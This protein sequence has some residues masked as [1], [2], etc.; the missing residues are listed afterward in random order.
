[1]EFMQPSQT[2]YLTFT[3]GVERSPPQEAVTE[4]IE[5]QD[6]ASIHQDL[7]W[8]ASQKSN[9]VCTRHHARK[10]DHCFVWNEWSG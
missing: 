10:W 7:S 4:K 8:A 2:P 1:M 6:N 5:Q 9:T 3:R